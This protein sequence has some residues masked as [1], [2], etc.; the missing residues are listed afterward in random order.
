M[1]VKDMGLSWIVV[2]DMAKA[3]ALYIDILGFEIYEENKYNLDLPKEQEI[4]H[5]GV[6]KKVNHNP[7]IVQ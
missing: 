7:S 2:S 6:E 3:K 1:Q 4:R 5:F